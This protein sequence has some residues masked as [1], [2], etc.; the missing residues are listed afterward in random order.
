MALAPKKVAQ[1]QEG[2][3]ADLKASIGGKDHKE[4][5]KKLGK[6]FPQGPLFTEKDVANIRELAKHP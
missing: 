3:K 5:A 6:R 2:A 1:T 4:A